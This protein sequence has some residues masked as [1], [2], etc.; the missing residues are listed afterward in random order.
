[1][2]VA[3]ISDRAIASEFDGCQRSVLFRVSSFEPTR[4]DLRVLACLRR[5]HGSFGPPEV[6]SPSLKKRGQG[7]FINVRAIKSTNQIPLK[8]PFFKGGSNSNSIRVTPIPR[9]VLDK[10]RKGRF[11]RNKVKLC[12]EARRTENSYQRKRTSGFSVF[13]CLSFARSSSRFKFPSR[14]SRCTEATSS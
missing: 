1:V 5:L 10:N 9:R 3:Q 14:A 13:G 2:P 4:K 11:E 7:R 6:N 8:S 12:R